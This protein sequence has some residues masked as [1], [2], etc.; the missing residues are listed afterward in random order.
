[1]KN[2]SSEIDF[3]PFVLLACKK[4]DGSANFLEIREFIEKNMNLLTMDKMG[5][6]SR[7]DTEPSWHQVI[8]NLKSH[9]TLEK[10]G[11][12]EHIPSGFRLTD[13]GNYVTGRIFKD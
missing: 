3:V 2:Q 11:L 10:L 12:V 5:F 7:S 6:L 8:R 4:N 13:E 9:K 1:M